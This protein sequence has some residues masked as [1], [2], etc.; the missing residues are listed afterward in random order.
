MTM[1][2]RAGGEPAQQGHKSVFCCGAPIHSTNG[3]SSTAPAAR[4]SRGRSTAAGSRR[5][6]AALATD[7]LS[8]PSVAVASFAVASFAVE[9]PS[10]DR[11]FNSNMIEKLVP[12][13]P[14]F[15]ALVR[16]VRLWAK[17]RGLYSNKMGYLGGV[18]CNI[19]AG[20]SLRSSASFTPMLL[21]PFCSSVSSIFSGSDGINPC[22]RFCVNAAHVTTIPCQSCRIEVPHQPCSSSGAAI[23]CGCRAITAVTL[24]ACGDPPR[25]RD[26]S[27][28]IIAPPF[29]S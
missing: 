7:G 25:E 17:R 12:D 14:A 4:G 10:S 27:G 28:V 9:L 22:L 3:A 5:C 23:V 19:L 13:F 15:L 29:S 8:A 18:N 21:R 26:G 24:R 11:C 16:C 2:A 6:V 20:S 1:V